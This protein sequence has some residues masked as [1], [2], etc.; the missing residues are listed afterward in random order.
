[1]TYAYI[2]LLVTAA[3][4]AA[5]T[6]LQT[7]LTVLF[8]RRRTEESGRLPFVSILKP[9]CGLDDDL[10]RNLASFAA[11]HGVDYEV[12]C[13]V[14]DPNDPAIAVLERVT[15]AYPDAPFR[16]VVGGDPMLERTN[17][18]VARLIAAERVARG[19]VLLISD[20]NVRVEPGDVASTVEV[21]SET[22]A[23]CVSN[24]F[25]GEGAE[26][27]GARIESLHLLSFVVPGNVLAAFGDV[28]CVV[29]KSM[30]VTREALS[31]IG[32]FAAFTNV[33]AEDQ[34]IGLAMREAGY[35]VVLSPVV[36][37]NVVVKRTLRRAL[38]RQ[39]RW[40]KIRY[41][42]SK[43]VYTSEL[44]VF[45]LPLALLASLAGMGRAFLLPP[46]I[47][48]LRLLQ[49][50][51]LARAAGA[52]IGMR[53]LLLVPL[54]DILQFGAQFIPYFDDTITWRGYRARLGRNTTLLEIMEAAA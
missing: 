54:L 17:R 4:A 12:I 16:L 33:L 10:D 32:G 25:T 48:A 14:A 46:A 19:D 26:T 37:R 35:R 5:I 8:R 28:P 51:V 36:I 24:L 34:V 38:D 9:L 22:R 18:K 7:V 49:V 44:L 45:P 30:A 40:N 1:M 52:R 42:M 2:V 50:A 15:N 39:I 23:G 20:S 43:G 6:T 27:L 21:L 3:A 11:L 47:V 41:A 31:A 53:D 13:S 29:G